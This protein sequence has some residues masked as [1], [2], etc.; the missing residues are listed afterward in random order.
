MVSMPSVSESQKLANA[1]MI[2]DIHRLARRTEDKRLRIAAYYVD[3]MDSDVVLRDYQVRSEQRFVGPLIVWFRRNLTSH[4]RE[5]YV[6]P[7]LKRQ[8]AFNRSL[9]ACLSNV[10]AINLLALAKLEAGADIMLRDYRV[11]SKVPVIG[12]LIAWVRRNLTSH[13]RGPYIDPIFERQVAFNRAAIDLLRAVHHKVT[14]WRL[15]E[16]YDVRVNSLSEIKEE[17]ACLSDRLSPF[18]QPANPGQA[19]LNTLLSQLLSYIDSRVEELS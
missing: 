15:R 13:L 4:I 9:V 3:A 16:C 2:T 14:D 5:A 18:D 8:V 11:R 7:I 10:N 17:I 1:N 12:P 19:E 6:D